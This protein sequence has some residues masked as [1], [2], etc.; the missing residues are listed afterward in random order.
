MLWVIW[1]TPQFDHCTATPYMV[2][3]TTRV[4]RFVRSISI[5]GRFFLARMSHLGATMRLHMLAVKS[6]TFDV[7]NTFA[8]FDMLMTPVFA[9]PFVSPRTAAD[10]MFDT[11]NML[12]YCSGW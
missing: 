6:C 9:G 12:S 4:A 2:D 8:P 3:A 5:F 10:T 11:P 7:K 1:R